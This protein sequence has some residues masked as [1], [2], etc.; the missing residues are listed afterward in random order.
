MDTERPAARAAALVLAVQIALFVGL[1]LPDGAL[2]VAWPSMRTGLDRSAGDLGVVLLVSMAGYLAGST[3]AARAASRIGTPTAMTVAAT[4]AGAA[5][6]LWVATDVW[7]VV[8]VAS[9]VL[10][11]ARGLVDAGLNAYVALHGG[12]R[13]LGLLHG[14]YG[15][16]TSLGPLLVLAALA[17]G[18]W[19]PAWLVMAALDLVVAAMLWRGRDDWEPEAVPEPGA[20]HVASPGLAS[21][22]LVV[23]VTMACFAALV[24]AE[25]STGAWSYT[26]LTDARDVS[27]TAAGLW[28]ATYWGGLTVARFAL[29]ALGHRIERVRLL[30]LSGATALTGVAWLWWDPRALGALGLPVAGLGFG[31]IFPTLVALMPDRLGPARSSTVIGWSVAAASIGGTAVAALAGVLVDEV[32]PSTLAPLFVVMTVALIALHLVLT[33]LAPVNRTRVPSP[34]APPG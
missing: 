9:L 12:V 17:V 19:R 20:P 7:L 29:G 27:D 3:A 21:I 10:G 25:F 4:V 11:M 15:V 18:T 6:V 30:H 8:L 26:L 1:G 32:G 23:F 28:V 16:G 2:G 31:C 14:A 24:G 34:A 13:R 22:A 33:A 5:F